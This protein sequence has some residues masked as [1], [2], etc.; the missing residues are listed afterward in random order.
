MRAWLL[1]NTPA[2]RVGWHSKYH[3]YPIFIFLE[4]V[5]TSELLAEHP[6]ERQTFMTM[7]A[8]TIQGVLPSLRVP[9][10]QVPTLLLSNFPAL[11]P[12][13]WEVTAYAPLTLNTV[14]PWPVQA[15]EFVIIRRLTHCLGSVGFSRVMT[16]AMEEFNNIKGSVR[17]FSLA[18]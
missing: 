1:G 17:P 15:P 18:L 16:V 2:A 6:F 12:S 14:A 10:G 8:S 5:L 13:I 7:V 9:I 3:A 4:N 11:D